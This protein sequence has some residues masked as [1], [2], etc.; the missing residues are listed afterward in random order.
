MALTDCNIHGVESIDQAR[1]LQK[2]NIDKL[3]ESLEKMHKDVYQTLLAFEESAIERHNVKTHVGPYRTTGRPR[4]RSR[5]RRPCR[6]HQLAST[7][8]YHGR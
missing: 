8:G 2:L 6:R 4:G 3:L 5:A 7:A 1:I